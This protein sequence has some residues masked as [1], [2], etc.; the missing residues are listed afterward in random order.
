MRI[1]RHL[2][3]LISVEE[4]VINIE[5]GSNKGLLVSRRYGNR[6]PVCRRKRVDGPEALT[7]RSDVKIDLDLVVLESNQGK[8]K[9]GV[10]AKPKKERDVKSGLRESIS[11]SA[12][13]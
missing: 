10:S 1:L 9:P 4:N 5:R 12:N 7:N 2:A 13:L 6:S 3:S 11:G 8:R